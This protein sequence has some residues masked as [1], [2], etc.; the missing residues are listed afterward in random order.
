[1]KW[2]SLIFNFGTKHFFFVYGLV[3]M[4]YYIGNIVYPA[5][6]EWLD[7]ITKN[8]GDINP[9]ESL[10]PN[11]QNIEHFNTAYSIIGVY[12]GIILE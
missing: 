1:M 2:H 11:L 6:I 8:C 12:F 7:N 4:L 10:D 9:I 5:P 3:I